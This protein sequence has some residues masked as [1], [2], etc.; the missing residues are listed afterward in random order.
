MKRVTITLVISIFIL[1][2]ILI[3]G[4]FRYFLIPQLSFAIENSNEQLNKDLVDIIHSYEKS[5]DLYTTSEQYAY[6]R[7]ISIYLENLDKDVIYNNNAELWNKRSFYY[8][9]TFFQHKDD[10]YLIKIYRKTDTANIG[11][12]EELK[13]TATILSNLAQNFNI[14]IC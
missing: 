10:I 6:E 9:T 12:A 14:F 1:N 7:N 13:K 5:N 4:Y 2:F 8:V 3:G 11:I